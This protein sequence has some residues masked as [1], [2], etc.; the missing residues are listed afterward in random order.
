LLHVTQEGE[1]DSFKNFSRVTDREGPLDGFKKF[2]HFTINDDRVEA[3][4][5]TEVF[6]DHRLGNPG[7]SS[8]L[9]N[10]GGIKS[11]LG[12]QGS[13]NVQELFT[14]LVPAHAGSWP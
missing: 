9:L 14:S 4:F 10:R 12:E 7:L 11:A 2:L 8:D 13:T 1:G 6:V 3:L 5:A